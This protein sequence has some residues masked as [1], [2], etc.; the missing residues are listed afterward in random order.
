VA[1]LEVALR[2]AEARGERL[3]RSLLDDARPGEVQ[4]RARLGDWWAVVTAAAV[5]AMVLA[6]R[7]RR[8]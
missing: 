3:L 2:R 5:L 7:K 6:A 4:P 8:R 1:E